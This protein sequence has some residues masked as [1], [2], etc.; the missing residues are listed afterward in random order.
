MN[1]YCKPQ[2]IEKETFLRDLPQKE[3]TE[4]ILSGKTTAGPLV[5]LAHK[6][7]WKFRLVS[8]GLL[9]I[10]LCVLGWCI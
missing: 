4:L 9:I 2:T 5:I 10:A 8:I 6:H 1:P 7:P 3:R